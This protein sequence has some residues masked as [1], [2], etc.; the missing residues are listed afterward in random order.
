MPTDLWASGG[1]WR[2]CKTC[3]W[4]TACQVHLVSI[5]LEQNCYLCAYFLISLQASF[6]REIV[7]SSKVKIS[8]LFPRLVWSTSRNKQRQLA[9]EDRSKMKS[10]MSDF[11]HC[12]NEMISYADLFVFPLRWSMP[13]FQRKGEGH[14]D[15][16]NTTSPFKR[17]SHEKEE[18]R[19]MLYDA[20]CYGKVEK[21]MKMFFCI[22]Y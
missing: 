14:K 4:S 11:S 17:L 1:V 18:S 6:K 21:I 5:T 13:S 20:R 19:Q 3:L 22:C 12:Y 7:I 9:C 15:T 2:G 8:K 10:V 16:E